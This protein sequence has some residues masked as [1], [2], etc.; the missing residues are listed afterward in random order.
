[1]KKLLTETQKKF[2]VNALF[3]FVIRVAEGKTTSEAEVLI[4]P[5]VAK[6]LLNKR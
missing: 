4:L 1:M 3:E 2:V 6:L 5:G